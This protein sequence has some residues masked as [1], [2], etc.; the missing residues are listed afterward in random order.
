MI[1]KAKKFDVIDYL[2]DEEIIQAYFDA[3]QHENDTDYLTEVVETVK[4]AGH[5][6][7]ERIDSINEST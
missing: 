3:S 7:G 6:L 4:K 1:K 5:L 2:D